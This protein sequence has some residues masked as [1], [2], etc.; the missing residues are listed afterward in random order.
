MNSPCSWSTPQSVSLHQGLQFCMLFCHPLKIDEV[1]IVLRWLNVRFPFGLFRFLQ[2][3][4]RPKRSY[5]YHPVPR[6]VFSFF[7]FFP[8]SIPHTLHSSRQYLCTMLFHHTIILWI[9]SHTWKQSHRQVSPAVLATGLGNQPA[10][11]IRTAKMVW[12][13]PIPVQRPDR[14]LH[15]WPNRDPY[16]STRRFCPVRLDIS[17]PISGAGFMVGLIMVA[18]R[19][20]TGSGTILNI[21]RHCLL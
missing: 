14:M 5:L 11:R 9:F 21:E 18:F 8:D 10:V 2:P 19:Y 3:P 1:C 13:S 20:P 15:C 16:L 4:Y 12:F 17:V 6:I 7:V